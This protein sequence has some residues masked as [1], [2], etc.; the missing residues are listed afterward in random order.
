[1]NPDEWNKVKAIL[2]DCLELEPDQRN[3]HLDQSC[4]GNPD[5]RL[6]VETLLESYS[7]AG[8]EFLENSI[9]EKPEEKL[10]GRQI[11]LYRIGEQIAEGGMG[12]VYR[13][14][15]LSDFQMQE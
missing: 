9:Q 3:A 14:V 10:T 13:A 15:P 8:D 12:A 4:S 1:M 5:L 6:E 7:K 2:A 11:G